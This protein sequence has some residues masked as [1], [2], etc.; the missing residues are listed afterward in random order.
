MNKS[1]L[2]RRVAATLVAVA[3]AAAG[4]PLAPSG[5]DKQ[6]LELELEPERR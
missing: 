6:V 5:L 2:G 3:A 1:R 4:S